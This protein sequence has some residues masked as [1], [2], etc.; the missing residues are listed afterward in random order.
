MSIICFGAFVGVQFEVS[1]IVG[2]H[3]C[4]FGVKMILFPRPNRMVFA[5]TAQLKMMIDMVKGV[6]SNNN[7][8]STLQTAPQAI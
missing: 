8:T 6:P 4:V 3:A 7:P 1:G 2:F 5:I